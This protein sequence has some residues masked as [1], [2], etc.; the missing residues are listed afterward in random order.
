MVN[1]AMIGAGGYA[2]ELIKR[3]FTEPRKLNLI[4]VSS[5]PLRKSPGRNFCEQ[6]GIPVYP[7]AD[8]KQSR[9]KLDSKSL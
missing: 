2:F 3:S 4:A 5:N 9:N 1:V 6:K 7:D 8:A